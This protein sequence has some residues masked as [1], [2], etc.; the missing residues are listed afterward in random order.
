MKIRRKYRGGYI[1]KLRRHTFNFKNAKIFWWN[2]MFVIVFV[3]FIQLNPI[4]IYGG[5]KVT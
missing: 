4:T 5:E 3:Y 1:R 2:G